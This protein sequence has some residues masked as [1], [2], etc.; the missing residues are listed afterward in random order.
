MMKWCKQQH[1]LL[2]KGVGR[3]M[4]HLS[5]SC[6]FIDN[7]KKSRK[8][9]PTTKKERPQN[10]HTNSLPTQST[11]KKK[12]SFAMFKRGQTKR[13]TASEA[14]QEQEQLEE[15]YHSVKCQD[16]KELVDVFPMEDEPEEEV[17]L[18]SC[19]PVCVFVVPHGFAVHV[20]FVLVLVLVL[21]LLFLIYVFMWHHT[22]LTPDLKSVPYFSPLG[23][24]ACAST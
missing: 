6:P 7:R 15:R 21:L 5:K 13:C 3:M 18:S 17:C 11:H 23:C 2:Q 20:V 1:K 12:K 19:S 24:F 22:R 10:P 8:E 9:T 16:Y 4:E 14:K